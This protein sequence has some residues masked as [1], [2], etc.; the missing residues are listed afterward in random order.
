VKEL[1]ITLSLFLAVSF[2]I[3]FPGFTPANTCEGKEAKFQDL[4][5]AQETQEDG[6]EVLEDEGTEGEVYD[7][8]EY[9]DG[10][11]DD[12][13]YDD[14]ED[15]ESGEAEEPYEVEEPA[16]TEEPGEN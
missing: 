7:D 6:G 13:G 8:G 12:E 5:L 1:K 15:E 4:T 11:Y 2:V 10:G 9:D 3:S 14:I 16:Q